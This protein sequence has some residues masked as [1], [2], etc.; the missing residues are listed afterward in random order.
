MPDEIFI[1]YSHKDSKYALR[2]AK[3]LEQ[4]GFSVWIDERID[5]GTQWPRVI[6]ESIDGCSAFVVIMTPRSYDS[7][8]VQNE[9]SYARSEDKPIFPLLLEGKLWVT[10]AALQ[11]VDV[12]NGKLPPSDFF[13]QLGGVVP[14]STTAQ[15]EHV[16]RHSV[17]KP[18]QIIRQTDIL[19]ITTPIQMELI[20]VPAGEFMMGSDPEMD[21]YAQKEEQPCHSLSV[22]EFYIGKF[23]V[24]NTQYSIF[25]KATNRYIPMHWERGYVNKGYREHPVV[26]VSWFYAIAFS[27]WLRGETD[28]AINLPSEAQWEYAARGGPLSR[29]YLYAG[30]ENPDDVAWYKAN[31]GDDTHPV[32]GKQPNEL[33]IYDMS[34]N[35]WEWTRSLWGRDRWEPDFKYPYISRDGREKM[36]APQRILRVLRGGTFISKSQYVR[37]AYRRRRSPDARFNN[38]GFR[39]VMEYPSSFDL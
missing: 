15:A 16:Y 20:R 28:Q 10:V 18:D 9:L 38:I 24:T 31:S 27:K 36:G 35:V 26:N 1:S 37:C 12:S 22:A 32:G 3:A 25:V 14:K 6:Q 23:P 11:Y 30:G 17:S 19:T 4:N 21:K 13:K 34:G 2:L 5:Y 8:W 29:G 7:V 33:G 39:V